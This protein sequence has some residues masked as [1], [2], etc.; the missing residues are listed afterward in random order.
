[1]RDVDNVGGGGANVGRV[2][3]GGGVIRDFFGTCGAFTKGGSTTRL[4]TVPRVGL[5]NKRDEATGRG[6]GGMRV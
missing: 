1:M 4:A 3:I 6:G 5:L 2:E